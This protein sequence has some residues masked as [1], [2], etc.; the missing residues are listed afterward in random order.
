MNKTM[1]TYGTL[2]DNSIRSQDL[3]KDTI[4]YPAEL[5]DYELTNHSYAFYLTIKEKKDSFVKGVIFQ[6][7]DKDIK[8]LDQYENGLYD[9][10]NVNVKVNYK[11]NYD[12]FAYIEK[13]KEKTYY[14][15]IIE[16]KEILE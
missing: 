5:S 7:N 13:P 15:E 10:I 3:G 9:R 16:C 11:S 14:N 8:R 6:V 2:M 4:S 12:S 1:F